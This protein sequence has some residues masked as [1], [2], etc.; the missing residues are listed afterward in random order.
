[1]NNLRR[2]PPQYKSL[3]FSKSDTSRTAVLKN[4]KDLLENPETSNKMFIQYFNIKIVEYL[5]GY[6]KDKNGETDIKKPIWKTL[7][8]VSKNK[9]KDRDTLCRS[10]DYVD[11]KAGIQ[12]PEYLR[13]ETFN[14][15]FI[16]TR[17]SSIVPSGSSVNTVFDFL[18]TAVT[19]DYTT[20]NVVSQSRKIN[21]SLAPSDQ[22]SNKKNIKTNR[23]QKSTTGRRNTSSGNRIY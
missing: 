2:L 8:V 3:V 23:R 13:F 18:N 19:I 1:M 9:I 11:E 5:E 22:N 14:R 6:Q 21:G 17:D 20:T 16:L 12:V 10:R 15:Y 7:D 4:A